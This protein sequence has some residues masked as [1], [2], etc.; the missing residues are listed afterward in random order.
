MLVDGIVRGDPQYFEDF[1]T[2]PGHLGADDTGSLP[3]ARVSAAVTISKLP[4]SSSYRVA[5]GQVLVP[6]TAA[7]R[8]GVQP[9]PTLAIGG[10]P[11]RHQRR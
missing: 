1:W 2:V 6:A 7:E 9:V 3:K 4:A 11:S 5:D 10:R 8:K